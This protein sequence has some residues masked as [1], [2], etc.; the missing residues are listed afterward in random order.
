MADY[1]AMLSEDAEK[2]EENLL[3]GLGDEIINDYALSKSP[4]P[5]LPLFQ[6]NIEQNDF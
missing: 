3:K 1:I 6:S 5:S 4:K 2:L